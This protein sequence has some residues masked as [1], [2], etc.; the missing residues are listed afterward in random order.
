MEKT[1]AV[2]LPDVTFKASD[3]GLDLV[4]SPI[5]E[6]AVD[7]RVNPVFI[8]V[9]LKLIELVLGAREFLKKS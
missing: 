6:I 2:C 5:W 1:V 3:P 7:A 9:I 8:E 4:G